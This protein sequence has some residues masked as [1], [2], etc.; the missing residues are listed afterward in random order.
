MTG[1]INMGGNS[2]TNLK[3]PVNDGDA[4]PKGYVLPRSGGAMTGPLE[5]LGP[6]AEGH[7]ASKG[8]VDA[9]HYSARVELP[10]AGWTGSGP[11][12]QEIAD[13]A[14]LASDC[15]HY[16]VVYTAGNVEAEKEAFALVD[17]L[18]AVDGK[19]IFRCYGDKP[20]SDLTVQL[21]V[22]R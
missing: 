17:E 18:E 20:E 1:S 13:T 16:G 2:I 12:A 22:N 10:A 8:Y 9:K 11:Y 4:A 3:T 7:A 5:V 21:E 15:P 14:I 19:L 6:T